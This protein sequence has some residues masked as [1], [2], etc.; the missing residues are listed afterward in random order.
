MALSVI[1]L[2]GS[3]LLL[4]SFLSLQRTPPG[5]DPSGVATFDIRMTLRTD[6]GATV[7]LAY[8]GRAD[9]SEA[10]GR[11]PVYAA[12][13]FESGDE[14]YAWLNA[15]MPVGKGLVGEGG[16]IVYEICELI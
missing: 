1:L 4:L 11:A 16:T 9:W 6:D 8:Q 5:F 13:T 14:R 12:M 3:S 15:L 7:Y 10:M 2:V